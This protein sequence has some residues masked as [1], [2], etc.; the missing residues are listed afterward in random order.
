[1][2][3]D[4][5]SPL[6]RTDKHYLA[7]GDGVLF[8]PPHPLWLDRPGFWDGGR[9]FLHTLKPL[10][11]VS[12]VDAAGRE[13]A[14]RPLSREW[15]P[16]ELAAAYAAD[17]IALEERR[18][19]LPGGRF[20]SEWTLTNTGAQPVSLVVVGWTAQEAAA[21]ADRAGVEGGADGV[22]FTVRAEDAQLGLSTLDVR[23]VLR[24]AGEPADGWAAYETQ[25]TRSFPNAPWWDGAPFRDRW[26]DG[27]LARELRLASEPPASGRRLVYLGVSRR[28][29]LEPGAAAALAVMLEAAPCDAA[30]R[31]P[32]PPP[33]VP[34]RAAEASRA[35]W[36][37]YF[38]AAPSLAA[39]DPWL[40]RYF[41]YR[42]YGLRLNFIDP[43]GNYAHPTVA[44]GIEFFHCP[45]AYSAWCHARELRWLPDPSRARGALLTFL[46]HQTEDGRLPGRVY[47]DH[48]RRTDFY[49]ADWGCALDALE[50][51]HPDRGFL[52]A[53]YGPLS[54]YAAWL[55]A[56][57]DREASG[58]Y[59]VLDPYETG[60]EN[61]SRYTAVDPD[62]DRQ[63]FDYRLRL[64]GVDL[65]V[66]AYRL[67]RALARA[68]AAL[69]RPAEVRAHDAVADRIADAVRRHMW[70]AASG[71]FSDLDP[72]TLARTGVRA[73]V[74]FY[75][76]MTDLVG[77]E[78][79]PGLERN[80]LDPAAFW[81]P[82]PVPS[83]AADDPT[84]SADA[85][86]K[87]VRQNCAWNGRVWPM[88]NSHL[89]DALGHVATTL[90]PAW[91]GRAAELL[92]RFVRMLF[93]D[94]DPARPNAFEHYSP[95][96]GRP[97][98][99]RGLDDYQHSWI[100]DLIIRYVAGFRPMAG[101]GFVVDAFP[102]G[103]ERLRLE[104]LPYRGAT[105]TIAIDDGRVAVD[106]DGSRRAEGSV[107]ESLE[108]SA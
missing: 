29:R 5:L 47:L 102:F 15:T 34:G 76:Y 108:V 9:L 54:R 78:H 7:A 46:D 89:V 38:A 105:V 45:I 53:A 56:D 11:T 101:G 16:A 58:L 8:D 41:A 66:Y 93:F 83:T 60:Q 22:A 70:D 61:M 21:L 68:A 48:M 40:E 12:F 2:H 99:Y 44:E 10:F 98:V 95:M 18:V 72:R 55:D 32:A 106:V 50:E 24:F 35:A 37:G 94:G 6:R 23:C 88:A 100:N 30:Y 90:D 77:P 73:A 96:T 52:E 4:A 67:R 71:M 42:W 51:V 65:T 74:C 80:L 57:R 13:L 27:G 91:R 85:E 14:P 59:D 36:R 104:R 86:W 20:V 28:V 82:Y 49:F 26:R 1:M 43:A 31:V 3:Q 63:H 62:A 92:G 81:L 17:G 25:Q 84:F 64:K 87:G 69:G 39:S 97:G 79:L 103:L 33:P 75:P 19:V 107:G